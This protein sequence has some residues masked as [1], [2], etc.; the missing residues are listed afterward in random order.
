MKDKIFKSVYFDLDALNLV[1]TKEVVEAYE[2]NEKNEKKKEK[3]LSLIA[4][5]GFFKN[6]DFL[7]SW[8]SW[9]EVRKKKK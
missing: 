9:N 6:S 3:A 5:S 1:E 7:E 8:K 4:L 2:K